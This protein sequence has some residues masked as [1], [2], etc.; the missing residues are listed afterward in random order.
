MHLAED[1]S[2]EFG[3]GRVLDGIAA[4]I[5]QTGGDRQAR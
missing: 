1:Q 2:F 3:L 4:S 5:T